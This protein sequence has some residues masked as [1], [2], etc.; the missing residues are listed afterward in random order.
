P[1]T[2]EAKNGLVMSGTTIAIIP[3]RP[4]LRFLAAALGR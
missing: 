4:D 3:V 2:I 1:S